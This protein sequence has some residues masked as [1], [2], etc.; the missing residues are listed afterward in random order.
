MNTGKEK[1]IE[2]AA[3]CAY[4]EHLLKSLREL[5]E[6]IKQSIE[7]DFSFK[8]IHQ[9]KEIIDE[10]NELCNIC[11]N[12]SGIKDIIDKLKLKV[13]VPV[14]ILYIQ[15]F[16]NFVKMPAPVFSKRVLK[17]SLTFADEKAT[18]LY[19]VDKAERGCT[20]LLNVLESLRA[21]KVAPEYA[22]KLI[23]LRSEVEKLERNLGDRAYLARNLKEAIEEYEQGHFLA[24]GLIASRVVSYIISKIPGGKDEEKVEKL[25][26]RGIIERE[27]RDEQEAFLHASRLSRN[28]LVHQ[29]WTSP[30]PEEAV[31][32][33][34][35]AVKLCN[36]LVKIMESES[37]SMK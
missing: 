21:P 31:E 27:R 7:Y 32:L 25:V 5:R 36:Y 15:D 17:S 16:P 12:L 20:T 22:D 28:V 30:K 9:F 37:Q 1:E 29:P 3:L 34:A 10:Y 35:H 6:S 24:S 19:I 33:I 4:A 13:F 11:C 23:S 14:E 18:A 2:L 8:G 26:E